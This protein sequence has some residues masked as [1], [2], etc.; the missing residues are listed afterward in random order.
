MNIDDKVDHCT[1]E[2]IWLRLPNSLFLITKW[3]F[4]VSWWWDLS[5]TWSQHVNT[6]MIW[7]HNPNT[8]PM[9]FIPTLRNYRFQLPRYR[10]SRHQI[11]ID[12][13]IRVTIPLPW[14]RP[15]LLH[16]WNTRLQP[17]VSLEPVLGGLTSR[18]TPIQDLVVV[19]WEGLL[20]LLWI[21]ATGESH[22]K[23]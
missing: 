21:K 1:K 14:L 4:I 3:H 8:W 9:N 11:I 12:S 2:G 15:G 20:R 10:L 17:I 19:M 18:S 23:W 6:H 22:S 7:S 5:I 13:N 16:H